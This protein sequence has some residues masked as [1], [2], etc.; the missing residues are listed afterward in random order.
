MMAGDCMMSGPVMLA[1]IGLA[2]L[3]LLAALSTLTLASVK[4]LRS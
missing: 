4:Y 1:T 2:G 3:L